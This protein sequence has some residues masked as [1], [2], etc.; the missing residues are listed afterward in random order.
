M[1]EAATRSLTILACLLFL[2]PG[3]LPKGVDVMTVQYPTHKSIDLWRADNM[4]FSRPHALDGVRDAQTYKQL[5]VSHS[6]F[7]E[8]QW[9]YE[10][11]YYGMINGVMLES[12]ALDGNTFSNT[13]MF[14]LA[15]DWHIIHIEGDT[16]NFNALKHNRKDAINIHA[17]LCKTQQTLHFVPS[18]N[19]AVRGIWEFMPEA[20]RKRWHWG[21]DANNLPSVP[22]M[23]LPQVL[24]ALHVRIHAL[25]LCS[26][27]LCVFVIQRAANAC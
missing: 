10:N 8:D 14:R 23:P 17:A 1:L 6:Q 21:V 26:K 5:G 24:S 22:C 7:Q 4:T 9:L 12:G 11:W 18:N 15:L 20:F 27:L 13:Y 2:I 3:V 25:V 19:A 16:D